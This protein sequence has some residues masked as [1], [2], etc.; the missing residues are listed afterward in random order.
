MMNNY[1]SDLESQ[2]MTILENKTS[3]SNDFLRNS[4]EGEDADI[5]KALNNLIASSSITAAEVRGAIMWKKQTELEAFKIKGLSIEE[6][7][8]YD[9]V[10]SSG[11][12]G[13][14]ENEIQEKTKIK[15]I[16]LLRRIIKKLETKSLIKSIKVANVK[17]KKIYLEFNT[18]PSFEITGGV[19]CVQ[20]EYNSDLIDAFKVKIF[21]YI[22]EQK[23]SG[24][25]EIWMSVKSSG[26]TNQDIKEKDIQTILNLLVVDNL[27]EV[28]DSPFEGNQLNA[29][30]FG[31]DGKELNNLRY[32]TVKQYKTEL[33]LAEVPCFYC[34]IAKECGEGNVVNPTECPHMLAYLD[35]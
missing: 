21:N 10:L 29:L 32:R 4:I 31:Y 23:V 20:Q 24:R 9:V 11:N 5:Q 17:N 16:S 19:F 28:I 7:H 26:L 14:T 2:I 22:S 25:K 12:I 13:L 15:N 27:V 3:V 35:F 18:V 8:C 30:L 33:P 34:P 1:I 6:N